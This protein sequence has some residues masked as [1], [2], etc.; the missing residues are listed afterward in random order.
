MFCE[1]TDGI[2]WRFSPSIFSSQEASISSI[3]TE[4]FGT[5][6]KEGKHIYKDNM[7][8]RKFHGKEEVFWTRASFR[9]QTG[10]KMFI[11]EFN[12][13]IW[14][15]YLFSI[16]TGPIANIVS[17]FDFSCTLSSST[18]VSTCVVIHT[19]KNFRS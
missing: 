12:G 17:L 14:P 13:S 16:S 11:L 2:F 6:S 7:D 8:C 9:F 1:K 5:Y 15:K 4:N 19:C 18:R 10:P 3:K